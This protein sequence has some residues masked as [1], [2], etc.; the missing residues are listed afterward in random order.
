MKQFSFPRFFTVHFVGLLLFSSWAT[1]ELDLH[2]PILQ[3][4]DVLLEWQSTTN[5]VVVGFLETPDAPVTRTSPVLSVD[6]NLNANLT[7]FN[8]APWFRSLR[9]RY[10]TPAEPLYPTS[11]PLRRW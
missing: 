6:L 11:A 4:N 10:S 1:G 7:V 8:L 3:L 2:P 5:E 9:W